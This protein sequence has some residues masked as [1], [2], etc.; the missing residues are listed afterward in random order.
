[1]VETPREVIFSEEGEGGLTTIVK[2]KIIIIYN[3]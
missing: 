2:Y 3:S 1:M